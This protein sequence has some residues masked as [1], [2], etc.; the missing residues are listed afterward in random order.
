MN[1][2]TEIEARLM[3]LNPQLCAVD[4]ESEDHKGHA[5]A[6]SGGHFRLMIVS[7]IFE[8]KNRLARHRLIYELLNDLMPH[9]IHALAIQAFSPSEVA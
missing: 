4:D 6:T 8:G 3:S 9:H 1:V 7:D 2:K 5:G